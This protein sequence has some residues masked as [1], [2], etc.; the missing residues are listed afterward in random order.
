MITECDAD[1]KWMP[2]GDWAVRN[3]TTAQR[4]GITCLRRRAKRS[5]ADGGRLRADEHLAHRRVQLIMPGLAAKAAH[6][7]SGRARKSR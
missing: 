4:A 2:A 6:E 1:I 7:S 5:T 3:S